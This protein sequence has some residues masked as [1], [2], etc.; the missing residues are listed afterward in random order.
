MIEARM[1]LRKIVTE[2]FNMFQVFAGHGSE[3][4]E[5]AMHL[6]DDNSAV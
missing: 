5:I 4:R 3:S 1:T 6:L 2:Q